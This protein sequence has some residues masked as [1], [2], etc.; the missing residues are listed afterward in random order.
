MT[1][2]LSRTRVSVELISEVDHFLHNPQEG[3]YMHDVGSKN[4][5]DPSCASR[6]KAIEMIASQKSGGA[7]S[8]TGRDFWSLIG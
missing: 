8:T 3:I 1:Q 2:L 7:K 6:S 4:F 5:K